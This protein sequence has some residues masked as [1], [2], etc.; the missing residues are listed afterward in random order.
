MPYLQAPQTSDYDYYC[1]QLFKLY[2]SKP[3]NCLTHYYLVALED[4]IIIHRLR[5]TPLPLRLDIVKGHVIKILYA[6][7]DFMFHSIANIFLI[8]LRV[9]ASRIP[10][11]LHSFYSLRR[12]F[13]S[14]LT[15]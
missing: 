15:K 6:I 14:F 13:S 3:R 11:S 1:S 9:I 7:Y 12:Y 2:R 5:C 10:A 4:Y 8:G